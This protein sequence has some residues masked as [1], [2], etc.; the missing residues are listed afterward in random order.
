MG[1]MLAIAQ[2]GECLAS[3]GPFSCWKS[4]QGERRNSEAHTKTCQ[5][6]ICNN[7]FQ[8][9]RSLNVRE[10]PTARNKLV[11]QSQQDR[12]HLNEGTQKGS[13]S[14]LRVNKIDSI[15]E[16]ALQEINWYLEVNKIGFT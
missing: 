16:S 8:Q 13:K 2:A 6:T 7:N 5:C 15:E 11:P 10:R 14:C 9:A 4:F 1:I 12:L 3:Q